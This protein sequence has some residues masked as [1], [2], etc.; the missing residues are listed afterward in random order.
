[1]QPFV[2]K[3]GGAFVRFSTLSPKDA[4]LSGTKIKTLIRERL[5]GSTAIPGSKEAEVEEALAFVYGCTY[6]LKVQ[7]GEDV[8]KLMRKSGRATTDAQL[9]KLRQ[10]EDF[11]LNIVVR[12]WCEGICPEWEF[13]A[14]VYHNQMTACTMYNSHCFVPGMP[15]K[16][17]KIQTMILQFWDRQYPSP[18]ESG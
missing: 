14:F 12:E 16:K 10:G 3:S 1:L 6:A 13:R 5:E 17:D 9:C 18:N 4:A 8:L 15:E 7:T 11:E 2:Q